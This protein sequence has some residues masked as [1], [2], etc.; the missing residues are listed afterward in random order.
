MNCAQ[1]PHISRD[2][3][4]LI[5][6]KRSFCYENDDEKSEMKRSFFR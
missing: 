6:E 3:N 1:K 4:V 5:F 2:V